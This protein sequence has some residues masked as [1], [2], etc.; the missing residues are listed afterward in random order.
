MKLEGTWF[1]TPKPGGRTYRV[2]VFRYEEFGSYGNSIYRQQNDGT[3]SLNSHGGSSP[4]KTIE[5]SLERAENDIRR[6]IEQET[7]SRMKA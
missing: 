3:F 6:T 1:F 4:H 5:E 2:E 7:S